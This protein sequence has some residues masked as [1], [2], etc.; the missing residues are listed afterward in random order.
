MPE[1]SAFTRA[2]DELRHVLHLTRIGDREVGDVGDIIAAR[3][4]VLARYQPVF[5]LEHISGLT[6]EEF[7]SFLNAR[8]NRHWR[9]L[10]R[11]G[12]FICAD[13]DRLRKALAILLDEK[14]P[15]RERL[16]R[17]VPGGGPAYVP[18]LHRAVLTP[19]LLV[20]HPAK[21]GVWN[22]VSAAAM[23]A[24]ALWPEM[25]G[26]ELFGDRYGKVNRVL[27][28]V[29]EA[30][31]IDLWTLDALWWRSGQVSSTDAGRESEDDDGRAESVVVAKRTEVRVDGPRFGLERHLHEFLRDNWD[32]TE[33]GREWAIHEEDGDPEAGYEYPCDVGRIDLLVKHRTR[34]RWLVIELKRDR[35]SDATVGQILRYVAWVRTHMAQPGDEVEGLV[36]A[37]EADKG[38]DYALSAAPGIGL[39]LYEVDFRL[40]APDGSFS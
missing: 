5:S 14:R 40:K 30:V 11:M 3:D 33:L 29:A 36:I 21:Y 20:A 12:P 9:G 31:G 1:S 35:S 37:H 8:N 17:L 23:Q 10:D 7:R 13:M 15:I 24:L 2:V 28:D 34:N 16:N 4:E 25:D 26:G 27:V 19:I 32:R 39:R 22:N 38:L 6:E 18:R